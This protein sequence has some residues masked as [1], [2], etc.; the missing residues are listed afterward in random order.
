MNRIKERYEHLLKTTPQEKLEKLYNSTI[1]NIQKENTDFKKNING[2]EIYT[3]DSRK[4]YFDTRLKKIEENFFRQ[5][6]GPH[7]NNLQ[8]I[9]QEL[10]DIDED[11]KKNNSH[12]SEFIDEVKGGRV[13]AIVDNGDYEISKLFS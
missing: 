2:Y 13:F 5:T 3:G 7:E 11:R 10:N 8:I 4:S 12:V 9:E 6:G 1:A